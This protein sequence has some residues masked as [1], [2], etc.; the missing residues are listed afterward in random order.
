MKYAAATLTN[1]TKEGI[2]P[3]MH[4]ENWLQPVQEPKNLQWKH[5]NE[6]TIGHSESG[7]NHILTRLDEK[8]GAISDIAIAYDKDNNMYIK[9]INKAHFYHKKPTDIHKTIEI[10]EGVYRVTHKYEHNPFEKI[11]QR[12]FD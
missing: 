8:E 2:V 4:G 7:H 12:V 9:V 10:Y 3:A 1:K 5:D 6:I 11:M